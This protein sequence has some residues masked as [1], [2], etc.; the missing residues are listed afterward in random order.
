MKKY[1]Q[2]AEVIWKDRKRYFGLPLSFTRYSI[3]KTASGRTKLVNVNGFFTT[4]TE[5]VEM[6]RVDDVSIY[7]SLFDKIFGVGTI[8]V[9]CRDA[10]CEKLEL[11]RVKHP[12]KVKEII[13]N[14]V[15]EDRQNLGVRYGE[16]QY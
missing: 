14:M 13:N 3:V 11:V 5:E 4:K 7:R 6:Y 10:S 9:Y 12:F 1:N 15:V 8:T 2:D 16:M